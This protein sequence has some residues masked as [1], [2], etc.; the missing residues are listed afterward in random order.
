MTPF[1]MLEIQLSVVFENL[2]NAFWGEKEVSVKKD[3]DHYRLNLIVWEEQIW[4]I[5]INW[6]GIDETQYFKTMLDIVVEYF[7][8]QLT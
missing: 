6:R 2:I 1:Y 5:G 7:D 8:K 4:A 3:E